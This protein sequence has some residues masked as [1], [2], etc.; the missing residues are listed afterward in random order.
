MSLS[1]WNE[2][3]LGKQMPNDPH[4]V[5]VCLPKAAHVEGYEE[6]DPAILDKM[7]LGYPRFVFHPLYRRLCERFAHFAQAD[8]FVMLWPG[9]RAAE[10][11]V[12]FTGDG[13]VKETDAG[14]VASVIPRALEQKA[15]AFWTHTGQIVSSRQAAD[16]LLNQ[17][18]DD[19]AASKAHS[20]ILLQI[21][22]HNCIIG[23]EGYTSLINDIFLYTSGMAAIY[24]AYETVCKALG[25]KKTVQLGFPYV[26]SWKIQEKFGDS[27]LLP[28]NEPDDLRALEKLL[29]Q[30]DVAAVFCEAPG[31]PLLHTIDFPALRDILDKYDVPLVVDDTI[32]TAANIYLRNRADIIVT[33]LTKFFS[34]MG[35]V[36]G[37]SLILNN[38]SNHYPALKDALR[39]VYEWQMYQSD[40]TVLAQNME[41]FGARM[42]MINHNGAA[43]AEF[44]N[45]HPAVKEVYH[46]TI[47]DRAAYD[48][49][50][51]PEGGYGGLLSFTFRNAVA[52]PGF[53]DRLE[54]PK[55]PSLG[56]EFTLVSPY[57]WMAHYREKTLLAQHG[58]DYNLIRISAG[59]ED[60]ATL[61]YTL[62]RALEPR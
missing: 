53:Y 19:V 44:L 47:T 50:R 22:Y 52:M 29:E 61:V 27:V 32:G 60:T 28:Y 11:C 40:L 9:R 38:R 16:I 39:S 7:V 18:P 10:Q 45:S 23:R 59:I 57:A 1:F 26:D 31:N 15:R 8:E 21:S 37:G 43:I 25:R 33:S 17:A 12:A 55:G 41:G 13:H 51:R 62:K 42:P 49:I 6:G 46:P 56:T 3:D 58:V 20:S 14:V 24:A 36:M 2:S 54:L 35:N 34:G 48:V 5:S 4:A 30:G